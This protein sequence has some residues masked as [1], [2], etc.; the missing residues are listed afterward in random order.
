[1][2]GLGDFLN[3]LLADGRMIVRDRPD[4]QPD[5]SVL[6]MLAEF[7]A[8][9]V[10][11]VAGPPLAFDADVALRAADVIY[12]AAWSLLRADQPVEAYRGVWERLGRPAEPAHH[13]SADLLLRFAPALLRRA[14]AALPSDPLPGQLADVLRAWPLSGVL[15]DVTEPPTTPVAFDPPGLALRYAERLARHEKP[16]WFPPAGGLQHV[17]LVWQELGRDVSL[18]PL[19]GQVAESF[20]AEEPEETPR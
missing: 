12:L 11:G 19:A 18:L 2:T 9:H 1:M 16:A 15:G 7:H 13:L 4:V 6:P 14:R 20:T 5:R 17:E 10:L 8:A 3:G